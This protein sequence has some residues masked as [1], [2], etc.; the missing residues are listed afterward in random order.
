VRVTTHHDT[1]FVIGGVIGRRVCRSR[2]QFANL[3]GRSKDKVSR[4]PR[5]MAGRVVPLVNRG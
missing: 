4:D 1:P 5:A 3:A 2:F